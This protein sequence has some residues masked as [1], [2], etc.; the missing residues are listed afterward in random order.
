[1][2]TWRL[3]RTDSDDPSSAFGQATLKAV[4][5]R[6]VNMC[7]DAG[8]IACK[9]GDCAS[10]FTRRTPVLRAT[11]AP[12]IVLRLRPP[13]EGET[14]GQDLEA[15]LSAVPGWP[16]VLSMIRGRL[17]HAMDTR[18]NQAMAELKG[19]PR[20]ALSNVSPLKYHYLLT[21]CDLTS[22]TDV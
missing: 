2:E 20:P 14:N 3:R 22:R 15:H 19:F 6:S 1:M 18:K 10:T 16:V 8:T 7:A 13:S 5:A 21:L 4:T 17:R 9:G 12:T 11:H